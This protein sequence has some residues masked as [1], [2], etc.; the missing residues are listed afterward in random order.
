MLTIP[1]SK[2]KDVFD[3]RRRITCFSISLRAITNPV[4]GEILKQVQDDIVL[5][6]QM[7]HEIQ[8]KSR[9]TFQ[10]PHQTRIHFTPFSFFCKRFAKRCKKEMVTTCYMSVHCNL[11]LRFCV[12]AMQNIIR[13]KGNNQSTN[14][15]FL[16]YHSQ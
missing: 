5:C 9:K 7:K 13:G 10:L 4:L 16:C 11:L 1:H 3:E 2:I 12:F 14:F 6:V 8:K 15:H